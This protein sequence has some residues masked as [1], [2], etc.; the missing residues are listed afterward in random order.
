MN[1]YNN[2]NY[3]N[4][5]QM[6]PVQ[7]QQIQRQQQP[8]NGDLQTF[9]GYA[10]RAQVVTNE[11]GVQL[12][13]MAEMLDF[14]AIISRSGL[15]PRGMET[16][17]KL[18]LAIQMGA[19]IGLSPMQ[20]IQNIAPINGRPALFGPLALGLV[21]ASGL[22]EEMEEYFEDSKGN[23]YDSIEPNSP[24]DV[25]AVCITK[26]KNGQTVRS[27]FSV[28]EA[29]T[30]NLWGKTGPW[31]QYKS[32]MMMHRARGFNLA[33]NFSDVLR[34]IPTQEEMTG[35]DPLPGHGSADRVPA[36]AT[37]K[38]LSATIQGKLAKLKAPVAT[39]V[40]NEPKAKEEA[41]ESEVSGEETARKEAAPPA[42]VG[43]AT[44]EQ[45]V[46][47]SDLRA[48]CGE[49]GMDMPRPVYENM[50]AKELAVWIKKAQARV[51]KR[52]DDE[53]AAIL[54]AEAAAAR[55]PEVLE[56]EIEEPFPAVETPDSLF[57]EI[58]QGMPKS[59]CKS[60]NAD[61]YW[62]KT[63]NGKNM[64]VNPDG[65][66]HFSTCPNADAHRKPRENPAPEPTP[67]NGIA[68]HHRALF[69][70]ANAAGLP[71]DR[72]AMIAAINELLKDTKNFKPIS[73]RTE[74]TKFQC[75][76]CIDAIE[77]GNLTW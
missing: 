52:I 37:A 55:E 34:G 53:R 22:L 8:Q 48:Q 13:T 5:Q 30:A 38:N 54:E 36:S 6:Q 7:Q 2:Q 27:T 3:Q 26:R 73:S 68:A 21:Q 61:I 35:N 51:E 56:G 1:N 32:R 15:A 62:I 17:E 74:L 42:Q 19:E 75:T 28:A 39:G 70:A 72:E 50:P 59:S 43:L 9:S 14:A 69:A 71:D 23:R 31:T 25:K 44:M 77:N 11:R 12:A 16:P 29:K 76:V 45:H 47:Y 64:P 24:D 65:S 4:N 49:L 33:D 46:E 41:P 63:A 20:A 57:F 18:F 67:Q 58:P 40:V 66:S 10:N 60:C